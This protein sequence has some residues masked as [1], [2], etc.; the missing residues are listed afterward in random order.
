MMLRR[1]VPML[2]L[3]ALA[4]S[5]PALAQSAD[6]AGDSAAVVAAV[7]R[8]HAA[9]AAGDSAAALALLAPDV[10]ILESGGAEDLAE[11]RGHHLPADIEFARAVRGTR[12]TLDVHVA[13]DVAWYTGTSESEG[14]FRERPVSSNGAELMVLTRSEGG[15]RIRAIHWS[16]RSRR[17]R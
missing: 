7:E 15:W 10:R 8:F 13:G 16:S 6:Q 12:R 1:F 9:L 5:A 2:F 14:V 4:S 11:Y 3:A 17:S